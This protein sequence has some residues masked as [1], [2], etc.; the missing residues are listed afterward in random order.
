MNE[1]HEEIQRQKEQ[2]KIHTT[3]TEKARVRKISYRS[4]IKYA[5]ELYFRHSRN[6]IDHG[7]KI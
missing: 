6:S 1:W 5:A 3:L 4:D 7:V 2:K